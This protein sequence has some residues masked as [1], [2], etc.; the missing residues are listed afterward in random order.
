VTRALRRVLELDVLIIAAWVMVFGVYF[1]K[2]PITD[3]DTPWH[4]ATGQYILT[5]RVVPTMDPFSWTMNGKPWVTQE[6][7]FELVL[8]LFVRLWGYFGAWLLPVLAQLITILALYRTCVWVTRGNR[9]LAALLAC[10]AVFVSL[11]FWIIRPQIISYAMFSIFLCILQAVRDGRLS[12][13][14]WVPPLMCLW[15]NAHAS[16]IIGIAMLWM[17]LLLSFVPSIGRLARLPLPRGARVRLLAASLAGILAALINPNGHRAIT[18]A[19]LSTNPLMVNNIVEWHS[20]DFH[21]PYF[22]HAIL[23]FIAVVLLIAVAVRGPLPMRETLY[24][25]G[26]LVVSLVYQRFMPYVAISAAPL[27]AWAVPTWFRTLNFPSR[28]LKIV[29]GVGLAVFTAW[30]AAQMA[31]VSKPFDRHLSPG[32]YPVAA[33]QYMQSHHLTSKVFNLYSW[34]GYLIYRGIPTFVDGR[35]DIFLQSSVFSDYLAMENMWYN[36]P[37]LLD[38]YNFQV[39]VYPPGRPLTT[40]LS[41]SPNWKLAYEDGTAA[42]YVRVHASSSGH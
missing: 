14:W 38:Q 12:A 41:Q 1:S 29:D 35:T 26:T 20:P 32:A 9:V 23:P 21:N 34:G 7:L 6:W 13:L 2:Q 30:F 15:S 11:D 4:L 17:E 8:A 39:V 10:G 37:N 42:V 22:Q 28:L 18:Y 40:Y 3:P 31:Y 19:L 27:V 33:V 16:V 25:G 36:A 5:Q 24:F